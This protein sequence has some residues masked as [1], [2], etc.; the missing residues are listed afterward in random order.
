MVINIILG[1]LIAFSVHFRCSANVMTLALVFSVE[2]FQ[3]LQ[4]NRNNLWGIL[5]LYLYGKYLV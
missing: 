5:F 2:L 3:T 1:Q 4:E